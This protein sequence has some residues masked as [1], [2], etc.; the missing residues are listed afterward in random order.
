MTQGDAVVSAYLTA[1]AEAQRE[2]RN[3][4]L[5]Q[6]FMDTAHFREPAWDML[7]DLFVNEAAD[8]RISVSSLCIASGVPN[9]TALRYLKLLTDSGRIVRSKCD[10]DA[11]TVHV[12][13]AD[14][15]R[16]ELIDYF[17][18][19][20]SDRDRARHGCGEDAF[21][22]P[23]EAREGNLPSHVIDKIIALL[24]SPETSSFLN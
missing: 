23:N 20:A 18:A 5:R 19:L 6:K 14:K 2:I 10:Q 9:T 8:R 15:C 3:R 13:L 17:L 22:H 16:K 7:V 12:N 4:L 11:R 24:N 1:I 21:S